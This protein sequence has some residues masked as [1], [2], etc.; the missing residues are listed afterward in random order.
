MNK[1]PILLVLCLSGSLLFHLGFA[2]EGLIL[3]LILKVL[4]GTLFMI[5]GIVVAKEG[6]KE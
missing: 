3:R 4:G 6:G 2:T 1:Y 5:G